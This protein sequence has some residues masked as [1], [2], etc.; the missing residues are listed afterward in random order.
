M[1]EYL[2]EL[3]ELK[4]PPGREEEVRNFI[5]KRLE[6]K[7][8]NYEED[9]F[10][11]IYVYKKGENKTDLNIAILAHIDEV[12]FI[13]TGYTQDGFLKFKPLGGLEAEILPGTEVELLNGVKGV[14]SSLPPHKKNSIEYTY[15]KL[16]IDIGV[17]SKEEAKGKVDIGEEGVFLTKF[18]EIG[19]GV[20][21]GKAF[22]D[23]AGSSI[24][25]SLIL[26]DT[27]PCDSV[28]IFTTQ[29]ETGLMG[30]RIASKRKNIDLAFILE[31]TFAFEPYHPEEEYYPKMGGGPVI[32]KM[33]RSLIVDEVLIKYIEKAA[34]KNNIKFQWKIPL[35]G[36][37]DAGV[38]SLT[39]KGVKSCVIAV[40]CR[41]IHSKASLLY[42]EDLIN[43][44][45]LLLKTL[46][47]MYGENFKGIV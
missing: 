46:E 11:N 45:K 28:L 14:I 32:T 18:E 38:I 29:E 19:K 22:D 30:A 12:G 44:K 5:K 2:K 9:F 21:K 13:I 42:E 20:Y 25:L 40:P 37:T 39:N 24:L 6:E 4:G 47:E 36:A 15:E 31:G 16:V 8:I 35:T 3:S 10:G 43:T 23:R 1:I 26:D 27:L 7:G 41:Y 17:Y 33:D 34:F